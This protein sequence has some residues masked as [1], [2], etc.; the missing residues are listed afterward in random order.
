MLL[1]SEI[2]DISDYKKFTARSIGANSALLFICRYR[3]PIIL[4][5]Y[6]CI[7]EE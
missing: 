6:V 5:M 2:T 4:Y 7:C 1:N 3:L